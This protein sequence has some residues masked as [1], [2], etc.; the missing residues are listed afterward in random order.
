[1]TG[2]S[3]NCATATARESRLLATGFEPGSSYWALT[4]ELLSL[5]LSSSDQELSI[6]NLMSETVLGRD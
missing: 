3:T 4:V 6:S 5:R 1:M 2:I